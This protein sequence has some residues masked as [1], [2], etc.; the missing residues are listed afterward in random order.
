MS[1]S[2]SA[3]PKRLRDEVA[4]VHALLAKAGLYMQETL[5]LSH[6]VP[7]ISLE[8]V[9]KLAREHEVYGVFVFRPA[10]H[11]DEA[12]SAG[13]GAVPTAE[14]DTLV[15]TFTVGTSTW[16]PYFHLGLW[17]DPDARALYV[18]KLAVDPSIQRGGL[19][20][21]CM[22]E[23]DKLAAEKGVQ[24]I[25]LDAVSA[26]PGL[27]PFYTSCGYTLVSH[28]AAGPTGNIQVDC[29]EKFM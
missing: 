4:E 3:T 13:A 11:G 9:Q 2:R 18:G 29:F 26:H 16:I 27:K 7:G 6:W 17:K 23:I 25:R 22:A 28:A 21:W 15:A 8:G 10:A 24:T 12:A 5:G 14:S 20:K 1:A 19:G